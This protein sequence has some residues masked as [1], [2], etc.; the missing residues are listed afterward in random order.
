M[1]KGSLSFTC[2]P[3]L[4]N[5]IPYL[6]VSLVASTPVPVPWECAGWKKSDIGYQHISRKKKVDISVAEI[7][8]LKM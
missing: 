2:L 1:L 5:P 6:E 7:S 3:Y 8:T 4:A